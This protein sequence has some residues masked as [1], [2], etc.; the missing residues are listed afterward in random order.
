MILGSVRNWSSFPVRLWS[1]VHAS[2]PVNM[3][4]SPNSA[5]ASRAGVWLRDTAASS[6]GGRTTLELTTWRWRQSANRSHTKE[7][8]L[9]TTAKKNGKK[10]DW[11]TGLAGRLG[12]K[13][14]R[15]VRKATQVFWQ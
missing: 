9:V 12:W 8:Q 14:P 11:V 4:P 7:I 15:K 13:R 2:S 10:V 1:R 5:R 6:T 3:T